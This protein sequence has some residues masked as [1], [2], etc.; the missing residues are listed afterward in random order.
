MSERVEA[1]V[2]VC[3]CVCVWEWECASAA[4]LAASSWAS[5][6]RASSIDIPDM[7]YFLSHVR[8]VPLLTC[9][10]DIVCVCVCECVCACACVCGRVTANA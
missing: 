3:V 8:A 6:A 2:C 7:K 9:C 5:L 4:A 10:M 1:C